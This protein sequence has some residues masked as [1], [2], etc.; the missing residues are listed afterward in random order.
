MREVPQ[1]YDDSI[2]TYGAIYYRE[3]MC[4]VDSHWTMTDSSE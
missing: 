2:L 1:M 4:H 3:M